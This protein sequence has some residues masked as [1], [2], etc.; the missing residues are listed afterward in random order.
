MASGGTGDVLTG[1][2]GGFLAQGVGY[3]DAA[4][5]ATYVHGLAGDIAAEVYGSRAMVATDLLQFIPHALL[6]LEE[7]CEEYISDLEE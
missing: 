6:E 2:I 5:L 7:C 1:L 4:V 3:S